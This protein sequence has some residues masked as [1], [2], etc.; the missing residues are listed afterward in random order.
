MKKLRTGSFIA[1]VL[2]LAIL[3]YGIAAASAGPGNV[4][5][6][7]LL[8]PID[9]NSYLAKMYQGWQ[10]SWQ[11]TLPYTAEPGAGSYLFLFYLFLGHVARWSGLSLIFIFHAARI[12]AGGFLLFSL[13]RFF[14]SQIEDERVAWLAFVLSG[15][16][17]GLGWLGIPFGALTSDLWVAEAYPFLSIYANPH[18]PLAIALVLWLCMFPVEP[19]TL[20][21]ALRFGLLALLLALL[22]PFGVV[23]TGVILGGLALWKW[24]ETRRLDW[25]KLALLAVFGGP[26]LIYDV[27]LTRVNPALANWNAQN[28]TP[29]P[30]LW[31]LLLAFSPAL[32]LAIPGA[33]ALLKSKSQSGR[34]LLV[35]AVAGIALL[36][37]PFS[38]QRRFITGLYVPLAGLAGLG[39]A[40][41]AGAQ[42]KRYRLLVFGL[43]VA[44]L[45]TTLVI[46]LA[47]W[48]GIQAR[49]PAIYLTRGEADA[50]QWL[51][52][53]TPPSAVV[54]AAP[55][56]GTL[57]P[58]YT[59]RRVLYGHPFETVD[60]A[61]NEQAV[62]DY[63]EGRGASAERS[64]YL[65]QNDVS[66]LFWGPR[67]TA[68][69]GAPPALGW[70]EVYS[71]EG[72]A[73]FAA[74]H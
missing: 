32:L 4:F 59:G 60:A 10:G 42:V 45:P 61:A 69:G 12:L 62:T 26:I 11:F 8:N 66:Y 30:P 67:E 52:Q 57:I 13:E 21:K 68:L 53:N 35:W 7:F 22:L 14:R 27:W 36:Y 44:V 33:V 74:P 5:G 20:W 47:A 38:L 50:F 65:L 51:A 56:T 40:A 18:F 2:L 28:V 71:S 63:I 64:A 25:Q 23:I 39:V 48:S 46:L 49:D 55:E 34:L 58:A 43:F 19:F 29:S 3:P 9:G 41:L 16:G 37:V 70:S 54:L 1:F 17:L 72:V 24:A 73:I 31:D 6:G 15:L